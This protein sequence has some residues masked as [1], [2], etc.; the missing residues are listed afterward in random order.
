MPKDSTKLSLPPIDS[1]FKLQNEIFAYFSY[2][3]D[4]RILPI[5]DSRKYFWRLNQNAA[6]GGDVQF[7][8]TE[9]ELFSE[10][11]YVHEIY[12]QRHLPRWVYEGE[13]LTMIVVDTHMD[14]NKL[15]QIF[16]N[17]KRRYKNA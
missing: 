1:Y 7:S 15:L 17:A 14:G 9:D 11:R 12:T 13:Q 6:G 2:V 3:E 16:D 8:E 10:G 4:W 5:D